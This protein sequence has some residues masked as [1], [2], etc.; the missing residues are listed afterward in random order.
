STSRRLSTTRRARAAESA[1]RRV[2]DVAQSRVEP[3]TNAFA[4]YTSDAKRVGMGGSST[5]RQHK[6]LSETDN[7]IRKAENLQ[8]SRH[9]SDP[10]SCSA[11]WTRSI[12][13]SMNAAKWRNS[14]GN[15]SKT[16]GRVCS[17]YGVPARNEAERCGSMDLRN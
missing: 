17:A 3:I 2:Q 4:G 7:G 12:V 6:A 13:I 15:S 10:A 8:V 9:L 11:G 16:E 1:L 14:T 5:V